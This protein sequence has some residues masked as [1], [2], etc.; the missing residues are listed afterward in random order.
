MKTWQKFILLILVS[1]VVH[2]LGHVVVGGGITGF[3][4]A[5]DLDPLSTKVYVNDWSPMAAIA[6]FLFTL[7]LLLLSPYRVLLFSVF[8][9]QS[10]W[11]FLTIY[12]DIANIN[13][14]DGWQVN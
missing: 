7:P 11:D 14:M 8:L 4:Y 12:I 9:F 13:F 6:G 10:R 2:E 5:P 1:A 3:E